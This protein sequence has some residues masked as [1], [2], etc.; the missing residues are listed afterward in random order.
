MEYNSITKNEESLIQY[1]N[2]YNWDDGFDIPYKI[3]DEKE[4]TLQVA[5][6]MFEFAD[7]FSYLETKGEDFELPEW[8]KFISSLYNRI[9]NGEFKKG[10]CVYNPDLT[11]V[12]IYKLKKLLMITNPPVDLCVDCV[13]KNYATPKKSICRMC[14]ELFA[15]IQYGKFPKINCVLGNFLIL[16]C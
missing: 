9:L 12:Q 14:G 7:G 6:L 13:R 15:L 1:I 11:R 10:E 3:L 16:S 5:L 2:T 4:C 8:S